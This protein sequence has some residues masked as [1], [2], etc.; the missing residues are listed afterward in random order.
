MSM[1][2]KQS[3]TNRCYCHVQDEE[4]NLN[5]IAKIITIVNHK[6]LQLR[7]E[8]SALKNVNYDRKKKLFKKTENACNISFS[9]EN[10]FNTS[11]SNIKFDKVIFSKKS[12]IL[13]SFLKN[14]LLNNYKTK[15]KKID[16]KASNYIT[17]LNNLLTSEK[18]QV[19]D[20]EFVFENME[21]ERK[22]KISQGTQCDLTMDR[23]RKRSFLNFF[24]IESYMKDNNVLK[25]NKKIEFS[26]KTNLFVT[27]DSDVNVTKLTNTKEQKNDEKYQLEDLT[28]S[29]NNLTCAKVNYTCKLIESEKKKSQENK[30]ESKIKNE[31]ANNKYKINLADNMEDKSELFKY[32]INRMRGGAEVRGNHFI[33]DFHNKIQKINLLKN[34]KFDAKNVKR[35]LDACINELNEIIEDASLIFSNAQCNIIEKL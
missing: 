25:P 4:I 30:I 9:F 2:V 16:D 32:S 6:I 10:D 28:N 11:Q 15:Y 35:R 34:S 33:S 23:K 14:N 1:H 5:D 19:R 31:L 20:S 18:L 21:K 12:D 22:M 24:K 7:D 27:L 29:E 8:I 3:T 26:S 13:V 17:D